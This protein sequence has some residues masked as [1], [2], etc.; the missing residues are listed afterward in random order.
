MGRYSHGSSRRAGLSRAR[1]ATLLAAGVL[2]ALAVAAGAFG[3]HA[4]DGQAQALWGTASR[5]HMWHVLAL[6][7]M[8]GASPL[9]DRRFAVFAAAA[10]TAGIVLFSG[11]L[12]LLAITGIGVFGVITP[13]GGVA[14]LA[15]WVLLAAAA[16]AGP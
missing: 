16:I 15:G 8:A 2:G 3:A 7:A 12:Y 5:Y 6:L 10:W 11:S 13:L 1:R 14:F 4:M 9:W